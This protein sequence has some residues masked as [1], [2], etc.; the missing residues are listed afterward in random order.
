M[1]NILNFLDSIIPIG[2]LIVVIWGGVKYFTK[3]NFDHHFEKKI[4]EYKNEMQNILDYNKFDL[5]RKIHDFS[6]FTT[7]MHET[8]QKVFYL[9]LI[10]EGNT[11][12]LMGARRR[13]DYKTMGERELGYALKKNYDLPDVA[14][15]K[16]TKD[17][18]DKKK[19]KDDELKK[20][21]DRWEIQQ[22]RNSISDAKNE[23]LTS[24]LFISDEVNT[25]LEE[26]VPPLVRY[27]FNAEC[28]RNPDFP[29][30]NRKALAGEMQQDDLL[31]KTLIVKLKLQMQSELKKGYY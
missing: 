5:Q 20:F 17:W 2:V 8:Y 4:I 29:H 28:L 19:S 12:Q 26:L 7:K 16:F 13:P 1:T 21:L 10:A 30:E 6:L 25:T 15:E 14:I 11:A 24:R 23:F 22:A 9:F 18:D 31:I 27:V 3:R